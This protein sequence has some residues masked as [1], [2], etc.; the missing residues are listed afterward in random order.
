MYHLDVMR[1]PWY[2]ASIENLKPIESRWSINQRIP[3]DRIKKGDWIFLKKSCDHVITHKKLVLD[4]KYFFGI[5]ETHDKMK[6]YREEIMVDDD[7]IFSKSKSKRKY[8]SLI[9]WGNSVELKQ[10]DEIIPAPIPFRQKGQ[11]SWICN[12]DPTRRDW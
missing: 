10:E 12:Y 8:L 9:W 1:N 4:V 2:D 7:Y 3:Y 11:Q 5:K 6:D